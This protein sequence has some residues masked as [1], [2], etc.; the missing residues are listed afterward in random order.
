MRTRVMPSFLL[1]AL[2]CVVVTVLTLSFSW[3]T[4]QPAE[5]RSA[6]GAGY[7]I[8]KGELV[9]IE[10][11]YY[12]LRDDQGKE[13]HLLVGPD[14]VAQGSFRTGDRIEVSASP[15][16]HAMFIKPLSKRHVD[17]D[18][19]A[20]TRTIRGRFIKIEGK[21]YVLKDAAGHEYRLLVTASTEMVGAFTPGDDL[22]VAVSPVEH[23]MS[24]R[25]NP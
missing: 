14:T 21:Y 4:A 12:V 25:S 6:L 9:R 16:E 22:E 7:K 11:R 19:A 20:A 15:I 23:A 18:L 5:E 2:W 17:I 8:V 10:G 24:I 3:A 13:M 1:C